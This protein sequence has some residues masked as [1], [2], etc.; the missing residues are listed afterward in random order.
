MEQMRAT[1][2]LPAGEGVAIY[3][4]SQCRTARL[5]DEYCYW[6]CL[7]NG[8]TQTL[9]QVTV[10]D[11]LCQGLELVEGSLWLDGHAISGDLSQGLCLPELASGD[12][13]ILS[14]A[15]CVSGEPEAACFE[16][17]AWV[18]Y[19]GVQASGRAVSNTVQVLWENCALKMGYFV[20]QTT[21]SCGERLNCTG[22]ITNTGTC[23]LEE[24]FLSLRLP[25]GSCFLPET[26]SFDEPVTVGADLE[27]LYLGRLE[28]GQTIRFRFQLLVETEERRHVRG[29]AFAFGRCADGESACSE[30]FTQDFYW[31]PIC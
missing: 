14:Y 30:I 4:K 17:T 6:L 2:S 16:N 8:S 25:Q 13:V 10:T 21:A 1:S 12:F 15:V 5:G 3:K 28:A 18:D 22:Y 11:E 7:I 27:R 9:E 19:Q 23:S 24:V 20:Q 26:L 29:Q 31:N